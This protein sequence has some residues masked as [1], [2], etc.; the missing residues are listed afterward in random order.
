[1]PEGSFVDG[2]FSKPERMETWY[3]VERDGELNVVVHDAGIIFSNHSVDNI[4]EVVRTR[5]INNWEGYREVVV[6]EAETLAEICELS[7]IEIYQ[8]PQ[9]EKETYPVEIEPLSWWKRLVS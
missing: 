5:T 6:S 7:I 2:D 3:A 9:W 8:Y 1:M 4:A